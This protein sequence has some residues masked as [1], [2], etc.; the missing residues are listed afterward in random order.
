MFFDLTN[1]VLEQ[2]D[3]LEAGAILSSEG[4]QHMRRVATLVEQTASLSEIHTD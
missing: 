2:R 3:L 4:W 1:D